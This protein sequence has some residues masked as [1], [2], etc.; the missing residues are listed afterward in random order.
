MGSSASTREKRQSGMFEWFFDSQVARS[1]VLMASAVLALVLANSPRASND[2]IRPW[3]G[4]EHRNRFTMVFLLSHRQT[5]NLA[6]GTLE[7]T[8]ANG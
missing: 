3:T 4:A 2:G 1:V 7:A 5:R 8:F 6:D